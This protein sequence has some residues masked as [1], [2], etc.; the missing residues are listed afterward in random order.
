MKHH[1]VGECYIQQVVRTLR[2]YYNTVEHHCVAL[3]DLKKVARTFTINATPSENNGN[4]YMLS[5]PA[6]FNL[7]RW[8]EREG[9]RKDYISHP[10]RPMRLF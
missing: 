10:G 8:I 1:K 2:P 3:I 5:L 6:N 7:K 4:H 9:I